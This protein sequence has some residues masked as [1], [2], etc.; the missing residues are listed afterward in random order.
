MRR[1]KR[2][3]KDFDNVLTSPTTLVHIAIEATAKILSITNIT[4][5]ISTESEQGSK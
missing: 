5:M 3:V 2:A 4:L 1:N